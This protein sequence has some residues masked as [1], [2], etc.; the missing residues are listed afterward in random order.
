MG[1]IPALSS[2]TYSCREHRDSIRI[3]ALELDD[4]RISVT[5]LGHVR[6][7]CLGNSPLGIEEV[8]NILYIHAELKGIPGVTHLHDEVMGIAE[9]EHMAE[10][11]ADSISLSILALVGG[12]ILILVEELPE[13]GLIV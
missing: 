3:D 4:L 10:R 12:Q 11:L 5:I 2:G 8:T 1:I 9:V 6:A 7:P 13:T